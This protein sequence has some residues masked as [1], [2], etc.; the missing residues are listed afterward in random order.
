MLRLK[1]GLTPPNRTNAD[2]IHD[3]EARRVRNVDGEVVKDPHDS[4]R[5][6]KLITGHRILIHINDRCD[7]VR[8]KVYKKVLKKGQKKASKRL[9]DRVIVRQ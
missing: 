9:Y 4:R 1:L 2:G 6:D 8:G 3:G 7:E 5:K